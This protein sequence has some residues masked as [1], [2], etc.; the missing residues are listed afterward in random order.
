MKKI[1]SLVIAFFV[2]TSYLHA[3]ILINSADGISGVLTFSTTQQIT[4]TT[5]QSQSVGAKAYLPAT[6][7]FYVVLSVPSAT[8]TLNIAKFS[9]PVK[10]QQLFFNGAAGAN[11]SSQPIDFIALIN[12]LGNTDLLLVGVTINTPDMLNQTSLAVQ[13]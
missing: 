11:L 7:D 13:T 3:T 12:A 4:T 5:G 1:I 6:V 2:F 8:P 9:R 10:G